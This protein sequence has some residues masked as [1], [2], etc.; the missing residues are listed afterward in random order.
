MH[1]PVISP[2]AQDMHRLPHLEGHPLLGGMIAPEVLV[3]R[4][5]MP[6]GS[7]DVV[8]AR[9]QLL[10]ESQIWWS[11]AGSGTEARHAQSLTKND[12]NYPNC[13]ISSSSSRR[14]APVESESLPEICNA[15]PDPS[16]DALTKKYDEFHGSQEV[17]TSGC[18]MSRPRRWQSGGQR[19]HRRKRTITCA[20]GRAGKFGTMTAPPAHFGRPSLGKNRS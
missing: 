4:W 13:S 12:E 3:I 2:I 7:T 14:Q 15:M 16:S 20:E 1:R 10:D 18:A 11:S 5:V 19:N 8:W 9:S 17:G 6:V